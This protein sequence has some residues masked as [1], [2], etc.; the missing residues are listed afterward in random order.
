MDL[1]EKGSKGV[2]SSKAGRKHTKSGVH[3]GDCR[4]KGR[5]PHPQSR[6]VR[7]ENRTDGT[8]YHFHGWS[9]RSRVN[10]TK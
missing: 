2:V 10:L 1:G 4:K 9:K 7:A 3:G 6:K 8:D 5:E